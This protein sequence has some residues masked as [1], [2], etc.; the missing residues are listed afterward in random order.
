MKLEKFVSSIDYDVKL[1]K[2]DIFGSIAHTKMLGNCGIIPKNDSKKIINGLNSILKDFVNGKLKFTGEDIHTSIETELKKRIGNVAGKMHTARSRNDQ[3]VLDVRLY[4]K[5]ELKIIVEKI[6]KTIGTIKNV[7]QKNLSVIMPGFTH[8][9]NAQPVLFSHWFL[10]YG[11]MLKRDK[12]RFLDCYKRVDVMPLGAAAFAGTEFP[13]D[14]NFVAKELGFSKISENSVDTV[15]DRDFLIEFLFDCS[16]VSMHLSRLAEEIII[17]SSQQFG[18]IKLSGQFTTGSSIMPQKKNPDFAELIRGKT[19][20]TY[21]NLISL[22][23][24]M[25]GLP[26]SY[27]RDM[28]MDKEPLFDSVETIKNILDVLS[29]MINTVKI[30]SEKMLSSC[31][32]GFILATDVADY[33]TSKS[34]P[35]RTAHNIVGKIVNYCIKNKKSFNNLSIVEWKKFSDKFEKSVFEVLDFRKSTELRKSNGGTSLSSVKQQLKKL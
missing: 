25:K 17:W 7:A 27:N 28:Q 32:N 31:K 21:G 9:Q 18:F 13:I 15:S 11:W 34:M 14:R 1:T 33:L 5:D 35:F 23:T 30:N 29:E 4:L 8:L 20:R 22:L 3:V 16:I 19:G 10:S 12:E 2:Y 24:V 26:L 6:D